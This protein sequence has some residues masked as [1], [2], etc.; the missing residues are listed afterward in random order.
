MLPTHSFSLFLTLSLTPTSPSPTLSLPLIPTPHSYTL[1]LTFTTCTTPMHSDQHTV[2]MIENSG[3][4]DQ[5][6]DIWTAT[7]VHA[8]CGVR[9]VCV[10]TCVSVGV[11]A[12]MGVCEH[13]L[14]C[15]YVCMNVRMYVCMYVYVWACLSVTQV[16]HD[17]KHPAYMLYNRFTFFTSLLRTSSSAHYYPVF[18][19][20]FLF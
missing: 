18:F 13:V 7:G 10:C 3:F 11:Y 19:L 4:P 1:F 16:L 9:Y 8:Y 12:G 20:L 17:A 15:M 5:T 14:D 6:Y 2:G